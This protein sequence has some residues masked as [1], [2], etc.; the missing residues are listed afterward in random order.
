M[1]GSKMFLK[2]LFLQINR[3]NCMNAGLE[4][5][6]DKFSKKY[7]PFLKQIEHQTPEHQLFNLLQ[8]LDRKLG[9]GKIS[10]IE[11]LTKEIVKNKI[12]R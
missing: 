3:F 5:G 11:N 4:S 9:V 1:N 10:I 6:T 12:E 7:P 8:K 2:Y